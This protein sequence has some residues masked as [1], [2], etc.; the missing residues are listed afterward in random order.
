MSRT[1]KPMVLA[2]VFVVLL[3]TGCSAPPKDMTGSQNDYGSNS[4]ANHGEKPDSLPPNVDGSNDETVPGILNQKLVKSADITISAKDIE[5]AQ[6]EIQA[7]AKQFDGYVYQMEQSQTNAQRYLTITIKVLSKNFDE[8]INLIK[9][10]G[11]TSNVTLNVSDVT[12]QFIDTQ[13]RIKTLKTKE[14]TLNNILAKAT[15][16][17]DILNIENNLQQTRQEIESYQGQLNVL[18]NSTDFS[19]LT[20]YVSDETGLAAT[21]AQ[22]APWNKFSNQF[23]RGLRYWSNAAIELLASLLFLLPILVLFLLLGLIVRLILK[24]NPTFRT[25]RR[26]TSKNQ[27]H[28]TPRSESES[29]L[30]KT[31]EESDVSSNRNSK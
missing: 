7:I 5:V 14:Q 13:A 27:P 4:D 22:E 9:K 15:S 16:I 25:K 8:A 2:F 21:Q 11:T 29:K 28:Y 23:K 18:K 12:T 31:D 3:M 10:L 24:R 19:K 17:E 30:E 6:T 26:R 20:V 1:I